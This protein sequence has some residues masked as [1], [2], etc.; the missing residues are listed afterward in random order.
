MRSR[1]RRLNVSLNLPNKR[2]IAFIA[3]CEAYC[4]AAGIKLATLSL[5][6]MNQGQ[7][8]DAIRAGNRGVTLATIRKAQAWMQDLPPDQYRQKHKP[9]RPRKEPK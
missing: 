1:T 3:E 7:I 5:R 8:L 2:V 6:M 4:E 9:G